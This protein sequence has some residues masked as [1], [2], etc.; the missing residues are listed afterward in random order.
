MAYPSQTSFDQFYNL[1]TQINSTTY[2][3]VYSFFAQYS[4]SI[5]AA[6]AS[7]QLLFNVA[8]QTNTNVLDLLKTFQGLDSQ[9]VSLTMAYYLNSLNA[10]KAVLYGL[11]APFEPNNTVQRNIVQ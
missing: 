9:K 11:N 8:Q 3:I 7:T 1:P 4:G 10:N 2:E 5:D 6:Q